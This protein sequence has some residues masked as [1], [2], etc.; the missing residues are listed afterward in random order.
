MMLMMGVD[1]NG[2]G[3][4]NLAVTVAW[5][6]ASWMMASERSLWVVV[7]KFFCSFVPEDFSINGSSDYSEASKAYLKFRTKSFKERA[8]EA[9]QLAMQGPLLDP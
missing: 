7:D 5:S 8:G 3:V 6:C 1:T 4:Y 2:L 9:L